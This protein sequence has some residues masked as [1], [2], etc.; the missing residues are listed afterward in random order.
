MHDMRPPIPGGTVDA[1]LAAAFDVAPAQAQAAMRTVAVAFATCLEQSTLSR[2]GLANL[3]EVVAGGL[4]AKLPEGSDTLRG[5]AT[6]ADGEGV[7][8]E[9]LGSKGR[10]RALGDHAARAA[11]LGEDQVRAMLPALAAITVAGLAARAKHNLGD[12][13]RVVPPLGRWSCGDP[14]GDL[15]GILRRGCGAGPY[16]RTKLR[17]VVRAALAR[18][19][20]FSP[21]G[22]VSWYLRFMLV[23]PLAAP[24][25]WLAANLRPGS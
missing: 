13:L 12:I 16:G 19:A 6:R 21:R 25:R 3:V 8:G 23:R 5:E 10:I 14:L 11:G 9:L 22:P 18:A 17:R 2:A 1:D 20:G 15:A 7:L 4:R 24:A